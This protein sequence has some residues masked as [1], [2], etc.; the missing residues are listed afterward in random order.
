LKR[1]AI[2]LSVLLLLS[3]CS[4]VVTGESWANVSTDGTS[5]FLT[6]KDK[7]V[8]IDPAAAVAAS[9]VV[10][11]SPVLWQAKLENNPVM[12]AAPAL[13]DDGQLFVGSYSTRGLYAM[14]ADTGIVSSGW[15]IPR[16]TDK[17]VASPVVKGDMVYVGMGDRGIRAYNRKSGQEFIFDG[18]K[19]GVWGTPLVVGD[20]VYAPSLDHNLYAL[21]A[22]NLTKIWEIDLGGAA[23]DT[24]AWDGQNMLYI[25]TWNSEVLAIDIATEPKITGR[26]KSQNWVWGRP[27]LDEGVLYFGDLSGNMYALDAETMA[28]KW[29]IPPDPEAKGGIRGRVGIAKNV[30]IIK[31]V[32]GKAETEAIPTMIVYGTEGKKV[33]AVDSNGGR[34]WVS[35][36]TMNDRILSD[37]L[38]V[39]NSAVFTTL[40]EEQLV[41]ALNLSTGQRDWFLK[42]ADARIPEPT[43]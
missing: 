5:V 12:Y 17:V 25:G 33:Y 29:T 36:V 41:V 3:G 4:S 8:K 42:A 16:F 24:P 43:K 9:G 28:Q 14:Q 15:K 26:F 38:I 31:V 18:M 2:V 7:L 40:S 21:N 13:S 30:S 20:V 22:S 10:G 6:Y 34:K 39:G 35:A 37:I 27:A 32:N 1:I 23:A 19:F 11:K